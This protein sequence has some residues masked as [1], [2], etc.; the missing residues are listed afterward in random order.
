MEKKQ[1]FFRDVGVLL[2]AKLAA[3]L[4]AVY[5]WL[6]K[7][8]SENKKNILRNAGMF[9]LTTLASAAFGVSLLLL[10]YG[11]YSSDIFREYMGSAQ[12]LCLN[13]FPIVCLTY[14]LY[15]AFGHAWLG[16]L[17]SGGIS[18]GLT[19]TNFF[20]LYFRDDPFQIEDMLLFN[21][22]RAMVFGGDYQLFVEERILLVAAIWIGLTILLYLCSP[23]EKAKH[24][25][26]RAG[27]AVAAVLA[28]ILVRPA[29]ADQ[30]VY[31]SAHVTW[32]GIG[33][34][35]PADMYISRGFLYPFFHHA[36]SLLFSSPNEGGG[37]TAQE[38]FAWYE[39]QNIPE[40]KKVNVIAIMLE[41]Y[42][43]F[44]QLGIAGLEADSAY[45]FYHQLEEESYTGQLVT[46]VFAAG[47]V[48]TERGFLTGISQHP[49]YAENTNSYVWYLR[50]QGY[51]VEGSHSHF[52]WFYDRKTINPNLGF[53]RYRFFENDYEKY[54]REYIYF[55]QDTDLLS[56]IHQDFIRN[57]E[58]GKPYF[59]FNVTV[60]SHGPYWTDGKDGET[61]Y[62]TG[63]YTQECK[64]A[65]DNYMNT[66]ELLDQA[67]E[68]M[69]DQLRVEEEPVILVLFGDHMPWM[70]DGNIFY[71]ELGVNIDRSTEEGFLTYYSTPYC[72]WANDAAKATLGNDFQGKGPTVS[73]CFLMN[74]LFE[75][76]G[77]DGPAFMQA[78]DATM[79]Q[80]PVITTNGVYIIEEELVSQP[81]DD[82]KSILDDWQNMQHYWKNEFLY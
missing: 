52:E 18:F 30:T 51:T 64:N 74:V 27:V 81:P 6:K 57:K 43:D 50:D 55:I 82:K 80:I 1:N 35:N 29:Y 58:T 26:W 65:M 44:S 21:E 28:V 12:L 72:I 53:E 15:A 4:F 61:T 63:N 60:A 22:A 5:L 46:N 40:E 73:P 10:A 49:E 69:V 7:T 76:C 31:D 8:D 77:W 20:K 48:D 62:L 71:D 70:G 45:S 32:E 56:E 47:T 13:V 33:I 16:F 2:V 23:K 37:K 11:H 3:A 19:L 34:Y 42:S 17:L 14:M 24:F 78:M 41:A 36:D 68:E 54:Q 38:I 25:L 9:L 39:D 79:Q 67:L 59:S 75:Q 66:I